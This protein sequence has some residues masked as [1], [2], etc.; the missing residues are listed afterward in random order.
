MSTGHDIREKL[1]EKNIKSAESVTTKTYNEALGLFF[2]NPYSDALP[3]F[4]E[5]QALQPNHPYVARY[6]SDSQQAVT[7]GKNESSSPILP[8]VLY[9]APQQNPGPG[10]NT[11]I[12]G[13]EA[14]L[15]QL[16]RTLGQRPPDER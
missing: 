6:I 12:A 13:L 1:N 7:A 4:R 2:A 15:E 16:R 14:E 8:W 11:R 3:K 5:V 10:A 9:G